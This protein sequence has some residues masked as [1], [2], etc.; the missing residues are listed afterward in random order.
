MGFCLGLSAQKG[1]DQFVRI[2]K[3]N[4]CSIQVPGK[5]D[6]LGAEATLRICIQKLESFVYFGINQSKVALG[7]RIVE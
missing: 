6:R 7:Q 4:C 3:T 1:I 2:N 5:T